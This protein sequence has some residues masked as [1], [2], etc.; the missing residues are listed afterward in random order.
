MTKSD[1][2]EKIM[3]QQDS[4]GCWNV[5]HD[6]NYGPELDY[7]VPNYKSTLWTLI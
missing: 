7:Y 6:D 3:D 1:L 5:E 2:I 4:N